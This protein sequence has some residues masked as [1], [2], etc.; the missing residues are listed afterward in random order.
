MARNVTARAVHFRR[1]L[2]FFTLSNKPF[3]HSQPREKNKKKEKAEQ[4][5]QEEEEQHTYGLRSSS[6]RGGRFRVENTQPDLSPDGMGPVRYGEGKSSKGDAE[7]F[8][9]LC[10]LIACP[11]ALI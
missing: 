11:M 3:I 9:P 5:G 2:N 4:Q 1:G 6:H 8:L 7:L 10:S